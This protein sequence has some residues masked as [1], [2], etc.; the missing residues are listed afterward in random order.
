MDDSSVGNNVR[1]AHASGK[2]QFL[3]QLK[4]LARI[5]ITAEPFDES[6]VRDYAG[7]ATQERH[8]VEHLS[9]LVN[10]LQFTKTMHKRTENY[11]VSIQ[12]P[13]QLRTKD[14]E[15]KIN[16]VNSVVRDDEDSIRHIVE[17]DSSNAIHSVVKRQKRVV[18]V[19]H[20]SDCSEQDVE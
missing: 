7:S 13:L 5:P 11:S 8:F 14:P 18:M 19:F 2:L 20:S 6:V 16:T 15:A 9:C 3:K 4:C 1:L 10:P 12:T 17:K